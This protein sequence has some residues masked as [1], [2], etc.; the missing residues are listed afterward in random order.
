[1]AK[2]E[3]NRSAERS[4]AEAQRFLNFKKIF[5]AQNFSNFRESIQ[6]FSKIFGEGGIPPSLSNSGK[7]SMPGL[8][9]HQNNITRVKS[10]Q[11][12]YRSNTTKI[13]EPNES[14]LK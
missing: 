5:Y 2:N 14:K 3:L 7:V 10:S 12:S 13:E 9:S 11:L 8:Q 1:M 6:F 4:E